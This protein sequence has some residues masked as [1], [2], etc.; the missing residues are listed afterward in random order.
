MYDLR[1]SFDFWLHAAWIRGNVDKGA[2]IYATCYMIPWSLEFDSNISKY[3]PRNGY[4]K[5]NDK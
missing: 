5:M 1:N 4:K 3:Y 2:T